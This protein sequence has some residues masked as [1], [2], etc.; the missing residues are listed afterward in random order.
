MRKAS[1][2]QKNVL[3]LTLTALLVACGGGGGG[4]SPSATNTPSPNPA[5]APTPAPPPEPTPEPLSRDEA[6][7]FLSQASFGP[8][9]A[10]IDELLD[11][12]LESWLLA[13]FEKPASLYLE[14]VLAGFPE[15]GR[16][17]DERGMPLPEILFLASDAFWQTSIEAP[18]QLRQRMAYALS[19]ILVVSSD[20]NLFRVPQ[21]VAHYMDV[22]T[23]GAFGNYRE[24]LENVTYSPAM[25][26]YL[27]YLRN[28]KADPRSGRV[29]DENYAR[30]LLQLFTIGLVEL[31]P[32]GTPVTGPGGEQV[33]LYTNEDITGLARVF[34]GLSFDGA[35]FTAPLVRLPLQAF[36]SPLEMFDEFHSTL[37]KEFLGTRIPADTPGEESIDLALDAIFAH[38]N[39]GPFIG[40]QLIQRFVTSAPSPA[41]VQRVA[42]AFDS[43][44][45][46]LPSGATA[47]E[48]RRGD[49]KAVIAAVLFDFE[50][51]DA[52]ARED[53]TFGKLREPVLRFTHWAR[54][55]KV[56]S[57][58]A[59]NEVVLRNTGSSSLLE[60]H[61]YRARSVFNFYRPGYIAAGGET[62]AT[63]LSAPEFQI[64]NASSLVGYPNFL[65]LY[66]LELSPKIDRS[67]P[68][69]Y[70]PDYSVEEALADDANALLDH[71]DTLLTHG[72]L[73]DDT[74]QRILA[75]LA[76]IDPDSARGR[77][78][79]A[80]LAGMMVMTS[81]EYIVLR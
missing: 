23:S 17:Y 37:P 21:T 29:P 54:A 78:L 18:D 19:Q 35:G 67:L 57:A 15:D 34:T 41:Y 32:D 44:R 31:G 59:S 74:R 20:S 58:D 36:Y 48:G 24:L 65:T 62:A 25:A 5:P 45:F 49:L 61:P 71:L 4:G 73:Q 8:D 55:F 63:G 64:T 47:G 66:A 39:L 12:G 68:P 70:V 80:R 28:V 79:R 51:R 22:L 50:A 13:E 43:G 76:Q 52:S 38:P 46:T 33:E 16:F 1:S 2:W 7:R 6:V 56:N 42:A 77:E 3:V 9:E 10:S 11:V 14:R 26:V 60:Q 72:T 40:R 75:A 53:V 30:E 81:P 69:A 27:T